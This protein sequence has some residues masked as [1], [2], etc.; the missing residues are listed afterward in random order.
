MYHRDQGWGMTEMSPLGSAAVPKAKHRDADRETLTAIKTK[1]GRPVFGV[2]MKIVDD[3]GA[4]CRM[5]E[6]RSA[7]SWCAVPG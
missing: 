2:E 7:N 1:A 3:Q 5:T 6:R 4:S